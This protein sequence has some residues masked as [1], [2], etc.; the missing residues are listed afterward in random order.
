MFAHFV[1]GAY[2]RTRARSQDHLP[3]SPT[4]DQAEVLVPES[5]PPEDI[6]AIGVASDEQ[7]RTERVRLE[8]LGIGASGLRFVVSPTLFDK[9]ALS[10]CIRAGRRPQERL[11]NA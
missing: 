3:C 9:R 8:V 11:W 6:K 2:G 1:L 10:T 5:I 4:D 7:A